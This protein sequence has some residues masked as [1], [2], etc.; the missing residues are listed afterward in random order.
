MKKK[1][2]F[3]IIGQ[4]VIIVLVVVYAFVQQTIAIEAE[5]KALAAVE[6]AMRQRE[7]AEAARAEAEKQRLAAEQHRMMADAARTEAVRQAEIANEMYKKCQG[8]SR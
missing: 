5:R 1:H 7:G 3:I 4:S 6:E 8:K 2:L